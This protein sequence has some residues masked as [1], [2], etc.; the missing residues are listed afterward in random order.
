MWW[1]IIKE[2]R[3]SSRQ[4]SALNWD[5]E[6]V[7]DEEEEGPCKKKVI[8]LLKY[9][10][11]LNFNMGSDNGTIDHDKDSLEQGIRQS[12]ISRYWKGIPYRYGKDSDDYFKLT[13]GVKGLD[14]ISEEQCCY[15]LSKI[16][17]VLGTYVTSKDIS[18]KDIGEYSTGISLREDVGDLSGFHWTHGASS[19]KDAST[20]NSASVYLQDLQNKLKSRF[21]TFTLGVKTKNYADSL[22]AVIRDIERRL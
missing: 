17:F 9:L 8:A 19:N 16:K 13:M 11:T 7:P 5:E 14:T 4:T 22:L 3:L 21:L 12:Y 10:R 20:Y 15:W 18:Q 6:M 1:N 2:T